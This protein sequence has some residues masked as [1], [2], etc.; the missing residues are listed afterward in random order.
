[1]TPRKQNENTNF[2]T[3]PQDF[4]KTP[5]VSPRLNRK[6]VAVVSPRCCKCEI[7]GCLK[8]STPPLTAAAE[9]FNFA[10]NAVVAMVLV[11]RIP[12][13][14]FDC[15]F[16]FFSRSLIHFHI[17]ICSAQQIICITAVSPFFVPFVTSRP[18]GC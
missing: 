3:A 2:L 14:I 5:R 16:P 17:Q 6:W 10:P 7:G 8:S 4:P 9:C 11:V 12:I 13:P 18:Y 15:H 1:M